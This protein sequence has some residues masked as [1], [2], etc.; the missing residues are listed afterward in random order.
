MF[1][2]DS[3][4]LMVKTGYPEIARSRSAL[5]NR[6]EIAPNGNVYLFV[7]VDGAN[8]R[9]V[10]ALYEMVREHGYWKINGVVARPDPGRV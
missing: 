5:V 2:R 9:S 8:G 6:G 3:F 1:D 4:E 10:E 7:K